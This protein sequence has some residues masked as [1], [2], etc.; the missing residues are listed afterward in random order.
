MSAPISNCISCM[1]NEHTYLRNQTKSI[2]DM[3]ANIHNLETKGCTV[4]KYGREI[5]EVVLST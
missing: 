1:N 5:V 2:L 4:L 3:H